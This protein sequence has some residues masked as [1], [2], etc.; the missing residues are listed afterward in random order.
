[1]VGSEQNATRINSFN[2]EGQEQPVSFVK[3]LPITE[4][5]EC[6]VY[7][8]DGDSTKDLGIIRIKPG[9]KTALQKVLK[10]EKTIEGY[11]S[12]KGKLTL[13][14]ADG[15]EEPPYNVGESQEPFSATVMV[16]DLMQWEAAADSSLVAYE[17]CLPP[18]ENG[19]FEN[20]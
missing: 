13:T 7:T 8:F 6:D 14:R 2:F 4:G 16:G 12:G 1:M 15:R 3:T 19:R 9:S 5:V 10:G 11:V 20:L 17:I 18:Y